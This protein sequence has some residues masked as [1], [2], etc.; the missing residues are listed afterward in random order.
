MPYGAVWK[1][2]I[3]QL[4]VAF[5]GTRD[6]PEWIEDFDVR[7]IETQFGPIANGIW[8]TFKAFRC[9]SGVQL[10]TY[11]NARVCGHSRGASLAACWAA[12]FSSPEYCLF[13]CPRLAGDG[14]TD[15]LAKL[16][17]T[18]W[19][20]IMDLVPLVFD[21]YPALPSRILIKPAAGIGILDAK[22]HH[23]WANYKTAI[24]THLGT[25]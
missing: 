22:A 15:R 12:Q 18:A 10:S 23:I 24:L 20:V 6:L 8:E 2:E 11:A 7:P 1:D 21:A 19:Q 4:T 3:G 17:G 13:A 14:V 5:A 9:S 16:P 25:V